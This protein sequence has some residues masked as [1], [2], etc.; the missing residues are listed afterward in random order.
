[1]TSLHNA[2]AQYFGFP[3]F[4]PGQKDALQQLLGVGQALLVQV[5][6]PAGMDLRLRFGGP[7]RFL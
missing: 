1:M 5:R 6:P 7:H 2:L 3:A 4:R